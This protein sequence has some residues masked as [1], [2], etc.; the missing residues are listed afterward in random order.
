MS[1]LIIIRQAAD[2]LQ[3]MP[4]PATVTN[5]S[6]GTVRQMVALA[7]DEGQ[8]LSAKYQWNELTRR[9][10]VPAKN[11][12]INPDNL[13]SDQGLIED[14]APGFLYII[15]DT[16]WLANQ[17]FKLLGPLSAQQRTALEAY[18]VQG[19]AWAYWIE[20]GRLYISRPTSPTQDL[21]FRYQTRH[22][23]TRPD[24]TL[25]DE[26]TDDADTSIIPERCIMLGVVWRWLE[27]NGL[28]Y[29][30]EY[31]NYQTAVAQFSGRDA[32]RT[33]LDASGTSPS[34]SPQQSI[35]GG[36]MMVR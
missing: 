5:S 24:G 34:Y 32:T 33:V 31:I 36:V 18:R 4:P 27:R 26:L 12:P 13:P 7:N 20:G 28:P 29:Q 22:W 35:I 14:I 25:G 6:D 15:D 11:A 23:V 1:L 3:N 10:S 19:A 16:L 8:E 9:V 2:R 21:T 17:P 30:Q